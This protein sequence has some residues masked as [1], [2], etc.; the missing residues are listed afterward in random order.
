MRVAEYMHRLDCYAHPL[1]AHQENVVHTTVTGKNVECGTNPAFGG[2]ASVFASDVVAWRTGHSWWAA[3]WSPDLTH[4]PRPDMI[5]D[6]WNTNRPAINYEGRYCGLWTKDFGARAQGW[7]SFLSGF[8]GYGYGAI[9][10]WLYMST[11]DIGQP[12]NDGIQEI[13]I[14]DKKR[15]WSEA[16]EYPSAHQMIHLRRFLESMEWWKLTPVLPRDSAFRSDSQAYVYARTADT[17]VLYFYA[18]S[19]HTGTILGLRPGSR[20]TQTW[21]NPRTGQQSAPLHL[22]ADDSGSLAL[23]LK[24]DEEDWATKIIAN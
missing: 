10:M 3:Q 20:F 24:P 7:I 15:P 23:P 18:R 14:E 9:D 2:G 16:L 11:Y 17:H 1:S 19:L 6:Y 8:F 21:F 4:S 22:Q 12:S 13:S 5:W